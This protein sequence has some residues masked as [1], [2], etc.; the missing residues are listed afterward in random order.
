MNEQYDAFGGDS[1]DKKEENEPVEPNPENGAEEPVQESLSEVKKPAKEGVA[2]AE[3]LS[4]D[5]KEQAE[6][7][8]S[9]D[10]GAPAVPETGTEGEKAKKELEVLFADFEKTYDLPSLYSLKAEDLPTNPIRNQAKE[11]LYPATALLTKIKIDPSIGR[12]TH[13]ELQKTFRR[14][15]NA[16][17]DLNKD[18]VTGKLRL[19]HDRVND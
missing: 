10:Y 3:D 19:D 6:Y 11:A 16:V 13:E 7:W 17:G 1:S 8:L 4:A 18:P 5:E 2:S 14:L 9:R 12:A 15:S